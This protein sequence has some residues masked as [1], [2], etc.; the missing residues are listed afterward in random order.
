MPTGRIRG[1]AGH[2]RLA[3]QDLNDI[4]NYIV[5]LPGIV[6][7][8]P[9]DCQAPPHP[10]NIGLWLMQGLLALLFAFAGG[11][12]ATQPKE[13]LAK[14]TPYVE[15][16]SQSTI[17][18]IGVLEVLAALGL[19]LPMV[20]GILPVLTPLAAVGLVL[21]MVGAIFVHLRRK[22]YPNI[23]VNV[24]ILVLAACVAYGRYVMEI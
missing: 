20:T 3:E 22:E 12:K 1:G 10:M 7:Q 17:R 23:A 18:L 9:T 8:R 19:V 13:K 21:T 6:N 16:Y 24:L 15:D 11:M 4:A 2:G 14:N 5:A